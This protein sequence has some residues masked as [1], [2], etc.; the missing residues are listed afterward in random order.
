VNLPL[1]Q[2][3]VDT[4]YQPRMGGLDP[5]HLERL[6]G[7]DPTQWPPLL[8][9]PNDAGGYDVIDGFHRLHIAREREFAT[10]RCAIMPGAG[11][12][13]AVAANLAHG[14]PLSIQDRKTFA[15]W[16]HEQEPTLSLRELARR[17]GL[18]D[19]T[20]KAALEPAEFPQSDDG[21]ASP[22]ARPSPDPI[23][24]VV[25]LARAAITD[26]VGV[27]KFA[28][29]FSGKTDQQQRAAYVSR[30]LADYS[31]DER[32]AVAMALVTL[33]TAL[34]DGARAHQPHPLRTR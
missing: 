10:I 7:S 11:Y 23:V 22:V 28:Q 33:G 30:V 1:G 5:D 27:N 32:P 19:K 31:D 13:E 24:R 6:R 3:Q 29:F 8:V 26:G 20:V 18:S 17:S 21:A 9:S 14:L 12:P 4:N 25:R 34:I 2:V 15:V 16:L